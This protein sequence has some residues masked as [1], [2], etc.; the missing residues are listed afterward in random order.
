MKNTNNVKQFLRKMQFKERSEAFSGRVIGK[1]ETGSRMRITHDP[2]SSLL[3]IDYR[4]Y[5]FFTRS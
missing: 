1:N 2:V 3:Q 5:A 4:R